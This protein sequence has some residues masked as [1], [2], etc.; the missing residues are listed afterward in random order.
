[1]VGGSIVVGTV[2]SVGIV[3]GPVGGSVGSGGSVAGGVVPGSG[4]VGGGCPIPYMASVRD[5]CCFQ[6]LGSHLYELYR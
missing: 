5:T 6:K 4:V 1:M 2:G 3:V